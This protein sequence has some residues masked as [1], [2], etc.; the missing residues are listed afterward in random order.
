MTTET[1]LIRS[2]FRKEGIRSFLY[3]F[4]DSSENFLW[5]G[6]LYHVFW[7][8]KHNAEVC[9]ELITGY[10]PIYPNRKE[11]VCEFQR[12][13]F[14]R[15]IINTVP[16]PQSLKNKYSEDFG[17]DAIEI[18][19]PNHK[20][21]L[22][23][24]HRSNVPLPMLV[25]GWQAELRDISSLLYVTAPGAARF[26]LRM[27]SLIPVIQEEFKRT[28]NSVKK[29]RKKASIPR[30]NETYHVYSCL[31]EKVMFTNA[32]KEKAKRLKSEHEINRIYYYNQA[33]VKELF[34]SSD[35][36]IESAILCAF[37]DQT[38]LDAQNQNRAIVRRK[39]D[40]WD[41]RMAIPIVEDV[42]IN[43]DTYCITVCGLRCL[44]TV[45]DDA[46]TIAFNN[47]VAGII[48]MQTE[49]PNYICY[50]SIC[51]DSPY[52]RVYDC[53][54]KKESL[55]CIPGIV[56][57]AL[58][59][60]RGGKIW[61]K[62]EGINLEF[63]RTENG[64]K[65]IFVTCQVRFDL[66]DPV[67]MQEPLWRCFHSFNK[68]YFEGKLPDLRYIKWSEKRVKSGNLGFYRGGTYR[69]ISLNAGGCAG[70]LFD[71][72]GWKG[73]LLHEMVHYWQELFG[74]TSWHGHNQEFFEKMTSIT[75]IKEYVT[76]FFDWRNP[77]VRPLRGYLIVDNYGLRY[78][79]FSY[80][81]NELNLIHQRNKSKIYLLN[82]TLLWSIQSMEGGHR[83]RFTV[84]KS[85]LKSFLNTATRIY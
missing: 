77:D 6:V 18:Q 30:S 46:D 57:G 84:A 20:W 34:C 68:Q 38:G 16:I 63:Q 82:S 10:E 9:P 14:A 62:W 21:Y 35:D 36:L 51:N 81:L 56:A 52:V 74:K 85:E 37:A 48:S 28:L 75:G 45:V 49:K 54:K 76:E 8:L 29:Q 61:G 11:V 43:D 65:R 4:Q 27:D 59:L 42:S 25:V 64:F 67:S 66:A 5:S 55:S 73:V 83:Y 7:S 2:I 24:M 60:N 22:T 33:N 53:E 13:G 58:I 19:L 79:P 40:K 26:I 44:V 80:S 47:V 72:D 1:K 70:A 69:G 23:Y 78:A 71:S 41:V 12:L 39:E 3:G 31:D 32:D 50:A 17:P 15:G